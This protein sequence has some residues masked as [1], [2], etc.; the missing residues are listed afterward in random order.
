MS[1]DNDMFVINELIE[2]YILL[3][4]GDK[5]TLTKLVNDNRNIYKFTSNPYNNKKALLKLI[6]LHN[7]TWQSTLTRL[8][9]EMY[10][11]LNTKPP[12]RNTKPPVHLLDQ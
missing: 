2:G 11:N 1:Q 10:A 8:R 9:L 3:G 4:T 6:D 5:P 12:V 7:T